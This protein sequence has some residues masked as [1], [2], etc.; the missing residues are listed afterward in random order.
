MGSTIF[1]AATTLWALNSRDV[2]KHNWG[3]VD[4]MFHELYHSHTTFF[5]V[6]PSIDN[7]PENVVPIRGPRV[8]SNK[9]S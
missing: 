1:F 3:V 5:N 7:L 2:W 6:I 8:R 4:K 9:A